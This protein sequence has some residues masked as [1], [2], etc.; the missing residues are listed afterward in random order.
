MGFRYK[1]KI[2]PRRT[3]WVLL[4]KKILSTQEPYHIL[5][6]FRYKEK[7][8]RAGPYGFCLLKNPLYAGTLP[9]THEFQIQRKNTSA[10]EPFTQFRSGGILITH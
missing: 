3:L 7:H 4:I 2:P 10:Q 9:Y 8:L 6:G 5:M 1:E